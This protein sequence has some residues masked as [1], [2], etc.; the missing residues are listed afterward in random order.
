MIV[1]PD[2][3]NPEGS[4]D[5]Y[6]INGDMIVGNGSGWVPFHPTPNQINNVVCVLGL[7]GDVA[8]L[9]LSAYLAVKSISFYDISGT[10]I[11]VVIYTAMT[12]NRPALTVTSTI[13]GDKTT[14][15]D[16]LGNATF[17]GGIGL[18]GMTPPVQPALPVTLADVI[19]VL[20]GA[21]L[22]ASS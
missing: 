6:G 17:A 15:I 18:N 10:T 9:G 20:V 13:T 11:P 19:S 22:C 8:A 16:N 12:G 3:A 7:T 14:V 4:C 21:G 2:P 1:T 5:S